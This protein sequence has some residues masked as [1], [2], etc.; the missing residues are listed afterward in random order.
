MEI[1][2]T[3]GREIINALE[4]HGVRVNRDFNYNDLPASK[5]DVACRTLINAC[6]YSPGECIPGCGQFGDELA[7]LFF[8]N[9]IMYFATLRVHLK[10]YAKLLQ[11][12]LSECADL[13]NCEATLRSGINTQKSLELLIDDP[14]QYQHVIEKAFIKYLGDQVQEQIEDVLREVVCH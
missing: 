14:N 10:N 3:Y 1:R 9:S 11:C 5:K 2:Q 12:S 8:Y 6:D 4:S 7:K 13:L